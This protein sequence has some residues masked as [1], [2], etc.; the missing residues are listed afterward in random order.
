MKSFIIVRNSGC[1]SLDNAYIDGI[2]CSSLP[3]TISFVL[4]TEGEGGTIEYS[5]RQGVQEPFSDIGPYENFVNLWIAAAELQTPPLTLAQAKVVKQDFVNALW[6]Q[7][8]TAPYPFL[9]WMWD[10]SDQ[11]VAGMTAEYVSNITGLHWW[12]PIAIGNVGISTDDMRSLIHGIIQR[13]LDLDWIRVNK[14]DG[15]NTITTIEGVIAF[16]AGLGW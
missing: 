5:D 7:K 9:T 3:S 6:Y 10:A 2:D 16:D 15:I 14:V 11:A 12:S 13:R 4:W 1:V 8:R